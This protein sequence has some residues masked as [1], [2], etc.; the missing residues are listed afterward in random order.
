MLAIIQTRSGPERSEEVSRVSQFQLQN[1]IAKTT[2]NLATSAGW[3]AISVT[4][5]CSLCAVS[6][7]THNSDPNSIGK[8]GK[9]TNSTDSFQPNRETTESKGCRDKHFPPF[10]LPMCL[11]SCSVMLEIKQ[12]TYD[13]SFSHTYP[14]IQIISGL[15]FLHYGL[16]QVRNPCVYSRPGD[17]VWP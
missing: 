4:T 10:Q 5:Y 11:K 3:K 13:I 17:W 8:L 9:I 1:R 16:K 15:Q 12:Q 2:K 7:T 6:K 14:P